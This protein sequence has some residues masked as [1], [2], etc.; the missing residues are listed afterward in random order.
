[1]KAVTF[2]ESITIS[3]PMEKIYK[4]LGYRKGLTHCNEKQKAQVEDYVEKAL[5]LIQLKG[6]AKILQLEKKGHSQVA[7]SEGIVLKS[8]KLAKFLQDSKDILIMGTTSGRKIMDAINR[9]LINGTP[10]ISSI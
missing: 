10:R 8:Q 1:M 7:L 9:R 4:R 5:S 3:P 6:A 2:F